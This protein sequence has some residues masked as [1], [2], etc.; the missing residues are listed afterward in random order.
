MLK[1]RNLFGLAA[2]A[3]AAA[4]TLSGRALAQFMP[5]ENPDSSLTAQRSGINGCLPTAWSKIKTRTAPK[6]EV[7]YKTTHGQPNG[8]ALTKNPNEL[9]VLDQ[10]R[11]GWMTLTDVKDGSVIREFQTDVVG[12]SGLVIDEDNV[13]WIASTHNTLIVAVDA[14][15][16]KTI[17][18]YFCPG[19]GRVYQKKGD[20]GRRDSKLP[21]AYPKPRAVGGAVQGQ[22]FALGYGHL[23]MNAEDDP[24]GRT[25][26]HGLL[27]VGGN[28]LMYVSPPSRA[29]FTID[30]RKWE[31][32][33]V[34]P[35]PGNR[36]HGITWADKQ[37]TH[38]WN[39]DSNL[40]AFYKFETT[41]GRIVEKVQLQDDPYTVVH[42]AKLF[43][44][45]PQA[46]Y[47]YFCDDK[48]WICRV[49]WA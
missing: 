15:T 46:G 48:G 2:L 23:A 26:A 29:I 27:N 31:V 14:R 1:R 9:W 41:T 4:A 18:K 8:L 17:G 21:V 19:S 49:K 37:R 12:P 7:L 3:P 11:G 5:A 36:P 47:M 39:A 28:I 43:V 44:D 24:D 16:G 40:N 34:F 38:F 6:I 33:S 30:K 25:G 22:G 45:G 35:T 20:P 10:G 42:G 13:M 32:Q